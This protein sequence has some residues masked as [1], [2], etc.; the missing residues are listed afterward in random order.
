M[1]KTELHVESQMKACRYHSFLIEPDDSTGRWRVTDPFDQYLGDF[2]SLREARS[3]IDELAGGSR[4]AGVFG[5]GF[6]ALIGVA[7]FKLYV[8][9]GLAPLLDALLAAP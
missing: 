4:L 1:P 3:Q 6:A 2:A 8:W 5:M 9:G 7:I